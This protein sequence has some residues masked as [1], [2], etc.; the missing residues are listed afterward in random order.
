MRAGYASASPAESVEHVNIFSNFVQY[1]LEKPEIFR[2]DC[3]NDM[4]KSEGFFDAIVCDP[5][6]GIRAGAKE[7]GLRE[8]RVKRK[9]EREVAPSDQQQIG[10]KPE[11]GKDKVTF[12]GLAD[13]ASDQNHGHGHHGRRASPA[14]DKSAEE[15]RLAGLPVPHLQRA[16]SSVHSGSSRKSSPGTRT[17]S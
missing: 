10:E 8:A 13:A 6:Y 12:V 17:S 1:G 7:C 16:V 3:T 11:E 15:R 4:F 14:R 9:E 5:P 2:M